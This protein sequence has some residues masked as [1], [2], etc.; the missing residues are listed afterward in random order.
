MKKV[1]RVIPDYEKMQADSSHQQQQ[2]QQQQQS[3]GIPRAAC[4]RLAANN[5]MINGNNEIVYTR[6]LSSGMTVCSLSIKM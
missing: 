2:Q 5:I 1:R 4:R 6:I 3:G